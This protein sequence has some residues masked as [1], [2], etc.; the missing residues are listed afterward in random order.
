MKWRVQVEHTEQ[1]TIHFCMST[2]FQLMFLYLIHLENKKNIR[3]LT[4]IN[5]YFR[6]Y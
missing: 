3:T 1:T 4:K 6:H 2:F 5:L